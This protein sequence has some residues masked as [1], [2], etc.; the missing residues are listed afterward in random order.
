[1]LEPFHL[2]CVQACMYV[3]VCFVCSS[4]WTQVCSGVLWEST[5]KGIQQSQNR[6]MGFLTINV[7]VS[8]HS[9]S[10]SICMFGKLVHAYWYR[11]LLFVQIKSRGARQHQCLQCELV[12]WCYSEA[13][14]QLG[15]L[16]V[17]QL[18]VACRNFLFFL[19]SH[20]NPH[21]YPALTST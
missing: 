12:E 1:M 20:Y 8:V 4:L 15:Q 16:L 17:H 14:R 3:K 2:C 6:Y 7:T 5:N 9:Y 19:S 11:S 21:P 13:M 18:S 10:M